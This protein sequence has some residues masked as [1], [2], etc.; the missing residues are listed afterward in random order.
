MPDDA[1]IQDYVKGFDVYKQELLD[2]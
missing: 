2:D 1:D